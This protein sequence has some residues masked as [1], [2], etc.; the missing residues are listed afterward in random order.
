LI[1]S[2][3]YLKNRG[4]QVA[5]VGSFLWHFFWMFVVT[6]PFQLDGLEKKTHPRIYFLGPVLT[7]ESFNLIVESKPELSQTYY[8]ALERGQGD[9]EPE[10]ESLERQS[11]GDMV[12]IPLGRTTWNTLKGMF[13]DDKKGPSEFFYE[14]F[15]IE[16]VEN[17]FPITGELKDRGILYLPPTPTLLPA[18]FHEGGVPSWN[19]SVF[20]IT[21]NPECHV[22]Q[23]ENLI[24]A[25]DPEA[26]LIWKKYLEGWK[27]MPLDYE[28]A[29][30]QTGEIKL[31]S[32]LGGD[33]Y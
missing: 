33:G 30:D 23:M 31:Q 26:D 24:S 13:H 27:F 22:V 3:E 32:P 29:T 12:S 17:P 11:P 9:F 20:G 1:F 6:V 4:L 5:I 18:P 21:V 19:E 2:P 15:P 25:G 7:D 10:I 16:I 28:F 8:E 14:K